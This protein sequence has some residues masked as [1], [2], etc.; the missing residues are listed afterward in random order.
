MRVGLNLLY[1]IPGISGG[2]ETYATCLVS[3]VV[4]PW[5]ALFLQ[6]A[7]PLEHAYRN[8]MV[9]FMG[10]SRYDSWNPAT[11][12]GQGWDEFPDPRKQLDAAP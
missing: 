9:S 7:P 3:A 12:A 5:P 2:T 11:L 1:L 10:E 6:V 4:I 8:A